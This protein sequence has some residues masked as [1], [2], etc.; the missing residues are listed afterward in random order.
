[1]SQKTNKLYFPKKN[2]SH[3]PPSK[4]HRPQIV[5]LSLIAAQKRHNISCV[6]PLYSS[7][8][9]SIL[10]SLVIC[11]M[12]IFIFIYV[13]VRIY[14]YVYSVKLHTMLNRKR[15][16]RETRVRSYCGFGWVETL[17]LELVVRSVMS[18]YVQG[19]R[20]ECL[21]PGYVQQSKYRRKGVKYMCRGI[22]KPYNVHRAA[23]DAY[24]T[25]NRIY[26]FA[27]RE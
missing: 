10:N 18:L 12:C 9:Y 14:I 26:T 24:R 4:A 6:L 17:K 16:S 23:G 22:F 25:I 8:K 15:K 13:Y 1:M 3:K 19:A 2:Y 21:D 7:F 5:T 27:I 20:G 11:C